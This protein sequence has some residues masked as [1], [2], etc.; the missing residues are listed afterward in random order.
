[1]EAQSL[2]I[3]IDNPQS[4]DGQVLISLHTEDTFM[5]GPGIQNITTKIYAGQVVAVFEDVKPGTYAV[6][7]LHDK[8]S[9]NAMDYHANGMPKE[10]YGMSNNP[11][12]F[13]PPF[14]AD[15]KFEMTSENKELNIRF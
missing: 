9:N 12:T 8:N 10:D 7:V 13:G 11:M 5:K 6:M 4:E 14:F 3:K 1:M 15:A 2:T